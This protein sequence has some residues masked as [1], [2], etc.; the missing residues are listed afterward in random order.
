MMSF[1]LINNVRI[2]YR[3]YGNG[4]PVILIH[5]YGAKKEIWKPQ[6]IDISKRFQ[7][8]IFDLRGTGESDR[9]NMPYTMQILSEDVSSLMNFLKFKK[10]HIIG[11]SFGGMIAQNFT[12]LYPEKVEKLVLIATNYGMHDTEWVD[13]PKKG[14]LT[15]IETLKHDPLKAFKEKSKWVFHIRF[16]KELEANPTKKFHNAFSMEDLIKESTINPSRPQDIINQAEAM[17]THYTLERLGEIKCKTLLIAAS[18][19]RQTPVSVMKEMNERIPNSELK[20]IQEAGHFMT[21]S[22]APEVNKMILD[23]LMD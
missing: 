5:G 7:V 10:A 19:D 15:E 22:R 13:I 18:H 9:P 4:F 23:F 21:L 14:R 20:I 8:I 17:K 11:R 6:V 16:R 3:A 2:S 12:L 1:A